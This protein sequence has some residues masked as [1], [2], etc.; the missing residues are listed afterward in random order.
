[1]ER[2]ERVARALCKS[3]RLPENTRYEGRPMWESFI[4]QAVVALDAADRDCREDATENISS[5]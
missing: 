5:R 4:P 1:M 3:Q 2:I